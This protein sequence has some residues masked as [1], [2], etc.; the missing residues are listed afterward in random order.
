MNG[1]DIKN[2]IYDSKNGF[3]KTYTA[4]APFVDSG[5]LW[6]F[7]ITVATND[8]WMNCIVFANEFGIPPVKSLLY[9]YKQFKNPPAD[10]KFGVQ[11]SRWLGAFMGFIFKFC[12]GYQSQK[13]RI[14]VDEYGIGTATKYLDPPTGFNIIWQTADNF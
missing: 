14:Q 10:F 8:Q 4:A 5:D 6:D 7:C 13:G 9:F 1:V 3:A 2:R 12:F 11:Y